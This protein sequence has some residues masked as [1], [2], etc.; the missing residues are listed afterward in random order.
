MPNNE[1]QGAQPPSVREGVKLYDLQATGTEL[2]AVHRILEA[3]IGVLEAWASMRHTTDE[4]A[5]ALRHDA[6]LLRSFVERNY[7]EE[8]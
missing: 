1:R 3:Q 5:K 8:S 7:G 2:G 6:G 4:E